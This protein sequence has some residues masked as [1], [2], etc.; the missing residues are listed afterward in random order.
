MEN[1]TR[2]DA[3]VEM[4][5]RNKPTLDML[6]QTFNI[7]KQRVSKILR[8]R[9]ISIV[10]GL[11]S[12]VQ[13]AIFTYAKQHAVDRASA[14]FHVSSTTVY[15]IFRRHGIQ[16]SEVHPRKKLQNEAA[17]MWSLY[18][19]GMTQAEIAQRYGKKSPTTVSHIFHRY[20]YLPIPE[21]TVRRKNKR[22]LLTT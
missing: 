18:Q 6:G 12:A 1:M 14:V 21:R 3:L 22:S 9:G 8:S 4:F 2:N 7:S 11:P 10:K 13:D 16:Y 5:L 20:G 15:T 17:A 19:Q